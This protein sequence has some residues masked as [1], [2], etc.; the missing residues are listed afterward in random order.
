MLDRRTMLHGGSALAITALGSAADPAATTAV[1]D[2]LGDPSQTGG[3]LAYP[4]H[5]T[6]AERAHLRTFDELD[7][8]VYSHQKWSRMGESHARNI[9]VHWP[10][11]HY[12]DGLAR[13]VADLE[14]QFVWAPDSRVTTHPIRI[15]K[16]NL[17][18]V[19]GVLAGT[20]SPDGRGGH[21][22]PT[23]KRF[24]LNMVTVGIWNRHGV[25]DE[26]F[27][28]WD[29]QTFARQIGLS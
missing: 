3:G 2:L 19:T 8:D 12:T 1:S 16:D 26:E 13:H 17:T 14:S 5:L 11:G 27:L 15:A 9:R 10:D 4:N 28:F 18:A 20:F 22:Q 6:H 29:A 21:I 23:G 24:S 25:M 7:F